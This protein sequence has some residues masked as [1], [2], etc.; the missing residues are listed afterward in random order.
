MEPNYLTIL[1]FTIGVVNIIHL[2][3]EEVKAS[4]GYDG[5]MD[6]L[7]TIEEKYGFKVSNCQW[8]VS[9]D[10]AV[11]CY[12]DGKEVSYAELEH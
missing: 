11:Y 1:D 4:E 2:T 5:F 10:L 6:F 9:E 7:Y 12:Q 8:M 3:P